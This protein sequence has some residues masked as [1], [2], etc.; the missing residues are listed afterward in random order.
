MTN[1]R[2]PIEAR[3]FCMPEGRDLSAAVLGLV[4]DEETDYCWKTFSAQI[5]PGLVTGETGPCPV[6]GH[7]ITVK[8][9]TAMGVFMQTVEDGEASDAS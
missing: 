4:P 9:V 8:P 7:I 5:D 1:K 2:E 3:F 6:C